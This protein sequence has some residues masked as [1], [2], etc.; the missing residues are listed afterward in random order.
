M[1]LPPLKFCKI[2]LDLDGVMADF[3]KL[4]QKY[5]PNY[6]PKAGMW[7]DDE[8]WKALQSE[9]NF[10]RHLDRLPDAGDLWAYLAPYHHNVSILTAIPRG[11]YPESSA[12]KRIWVANNFG[13]HVNVITCF[14]IEKQLYAAPDAILIDDAGRNIGQWIKSGGGAGIMHYHASETIRCLKELE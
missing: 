10:F 2:Y 6:R 13:E 3:D 7:L 4:V 12:D 14:G 8:L 9:P 5:F 1:A 11:R